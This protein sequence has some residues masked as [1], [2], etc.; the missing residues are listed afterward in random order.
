MGYPPRDP[1]YVPTSYPLDESR[2][3]TYKGTMYLHSKGHE[4]STPYRGCRG[5]QTPSGG[6]GALAGARGAPQYGS[7]TSNGKLKMADS[8]SV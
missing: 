7:N 8:R 5:T 3:C 2:C 4:V 1:W 6:R